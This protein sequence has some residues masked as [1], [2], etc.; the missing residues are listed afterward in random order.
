MKELELK[1]RVKV[2]TSSHCYQLSEKYSI[3]EIFSKV[4]DSNDRNM[5]RLIDY[6]NEVIYIRAS[7]IES[8]SIIVEVY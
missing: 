6:Q 4:I 5:L 3:D 7:M 1:R 2:S 8:I